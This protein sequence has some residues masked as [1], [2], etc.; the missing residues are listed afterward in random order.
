MVR[1]ATVLSPLTLFCRHLRPSMLQQLL[2]RLVFDVPLLTEY[3]KMPLRVR[4]KFLINFH[5]Y[6]TFL[7]QLV[8]FYPISHVALPAS[9][10]IISR[11]PS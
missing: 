2:H 3:C 6:I 11:T 8:I 5:L 4:K 10:L 7:I 1:A 9:N